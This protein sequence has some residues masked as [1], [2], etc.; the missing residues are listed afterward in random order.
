MKEVRD[1]ST[2][3]S[4]QVVHIDIPPHEVNLSL[5]YILDPLLQTATTAQPDPTQN[6]ELAQHLQNAADLLRQ[7]KEVMGKIDEI[8]PTI[9]AAGPGP[10]TSA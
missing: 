1:V 9:F 5:D 8:D 4:R 3:D 7:L 6:P 2:G 10:A